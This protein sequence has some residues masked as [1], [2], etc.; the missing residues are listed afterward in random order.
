M[1]GNLLLP[2]TLTSGK[3]FFGS[4]AN[5]A[6]NELSIQFIG[7]KCWHPYQAKWIATGAI[8]FSEGAPD[9]DKAGVG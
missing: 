3:K 5:Q 7:R 2:E 1:F 9:W 4:G 8:L 6:G